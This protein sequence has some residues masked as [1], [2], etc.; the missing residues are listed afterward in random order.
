MTGGLTIGGR[1]GV[2][3]V[4]FVVVVPESVNVV[5]VGGALGSTFVSV[6]TIAPLFLAFRSA[7]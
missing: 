1:S 7:S 2:V 6:E 4:G 3:S 5:P